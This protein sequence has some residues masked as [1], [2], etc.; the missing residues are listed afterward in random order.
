MRPHIVIDK[1]FQL[2]NCYPAVVSLYFKTKENP[3]EN[4]LVKSLRFIWS[5]F[6]LFSKCANV[7]PVSLANVCMG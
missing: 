1:Q 6:V 5:K 4:S 3:V 2:K 7:I